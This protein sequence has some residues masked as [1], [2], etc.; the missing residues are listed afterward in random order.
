MTKYKKRIS[1]PLLDRMD[2]HSDV[3]RDYQKPRSDLV[4]ESSEAI[5]AHVQA[6]LT[7][8]NKVFSRNGSSDKDCNVDLCVGG[9]AGYAVLDAGRGSTPDY[10][11]WAE[12]PKIL[13]T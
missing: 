2:I 1:G 7:M 12:L 11:R 4:E 10:H 5:R 3:P 13:D 8:Q 6:A 9:P